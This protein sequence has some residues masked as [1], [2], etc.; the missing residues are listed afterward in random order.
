MEALPVEIS[1]SQC[2]VEA[3]NFHSVVLKNPLSALGT[4]LGNM[5][6][7]NQWV[8]IPSPSSNQSTFTL[9]ALYAELIVKI[10][11]NKNILKLI[12]VCKLLT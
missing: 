1:G 9:F 8:S 3:E 7:N 4:P 11:F 6:E 12:N 2:Q 10:S 5:E